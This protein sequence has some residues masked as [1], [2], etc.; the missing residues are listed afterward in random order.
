MVPAY[1]GHKLISINHIIHKRK[2]CHLMHSELHTVVP[3]R[4][5]YLPRNCG[6]IR[7]VAFGEREK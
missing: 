3:L 4:R 1:V 5:P 2:L 6:H 7:E